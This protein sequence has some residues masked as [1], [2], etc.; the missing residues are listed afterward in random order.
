MYAEVGAEVVS[1]VVRVLARIDVRCGVFEEILAVGGAVCAGVG[2][3]VHYVAAYAEYFLV[4]YVEVE[5]QG[6]RCGDAVV[7]SEVAEAAAGSVRKSG[8]IDVVDAA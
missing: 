5:A 6:A 1:S 8:F 7:A 3:A 2:V 4:A